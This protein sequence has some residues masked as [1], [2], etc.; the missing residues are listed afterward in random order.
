L[1]LSYK[2]TTDANEFIN[3]NGPKLN[4]SFEQITNEPFIAATD[5]LF[6]TGIRDQN[7]QVFY[8]E[9]LPVFYPTSRRSILPFDVFACTFYM[10]SRY[11]EYLPVIRDKYDRFDAHSSLAYENNFLEIPVVDYWIIYLRE[12][13]K[14]IYPQLEFKQPKYKFILTIDVD[15]AYAY[16]EKGFVRTLGAYLKSLIKGDVSKIIER[17]RVLLGNRPD[18]YDTYNYQIELQQK[19]KYQTI[20]F[21]LLGDYGYNDTNVPVSSRKLCSLIKR[22]SDYYEIGIHPSYGSNAHPERINIEINRLSKIMHSDVTKSRQ[23]FLKI[24]LPDTY[25]ELINL[26]ITDDY[27]MGFANELGFRAGTSFSFNFYDLDNETETPLNIHP[28]AVMDATLNLYL[29]LKPEEAIVRVKKI[30]DEV[31]KVNGT[32][33]GLWH[34]ETLSDWDIW[35]GWK[36]VYEEMIK[37][38]C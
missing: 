18:P 22:L 3:Y 31:K 1:G 5:L 14:N 27:T 24:K 17:T 26:D 21:F 28:F 35:K 33:I 30:I 13:L 7:I 16:L 15:N 20:Y 23:H 37:Y 12:Q 25:R 8:I 11:E 34:N 36:I 38:A 4:Y 19:Y 6:Q 29:H 9:N 2:I 10:I 32:F